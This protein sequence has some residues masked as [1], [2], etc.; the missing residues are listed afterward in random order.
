MKCSW[1]ALMESLINIEV[2]TRKEATKQFA[3]E[4]IAAGP[5]A[6]CNTNIAPW[7]KNGVC[8]RLEH[9]LSFSE[10]EIGSP[11][12]PLDQHVVE[13]LIASISEFGQKEPIAVR[14]LGDGRLQ[15]LS[16]CHRIAALMNLGRKSASALIVSGLSD[17]E[18][19]IW[20][21]VD[22]LH[23]K[24]LSVMDRAK[25]DVELQQ[26]VKQKVSQVARPLGGP[27]PADK[28]HAKAA[29]LLGTSADRMARSTKIARITPEAEAK[30]RELKLENNQAALL[31]I[32]DAGTTT[33][34]QIAKAI[35]LVQ[36]PQKC[37]KF[38]V[39]YPDKGNTGSAD[40]LEPADAATTIVP[41]IQAPEISENVTPL[42]VV[43]RGQS[44]LA[45]SDTFPDL[46]AFL[47]RRT[48]N[49]E[50]KE[51]TDELRNSR[52][53][54]M[55]GSC[56]IEAQQRFFWEVLFAEF[57]NAFAEALPRPTKVRG[58]G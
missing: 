24:V 36:R 57:P 1:S 56:T 40:R 48:I 3:R 51:L 54:K 58:H 52:L 55:L 50:L 43:Q 29:A 26:A 17:S 46:P 23:R 21:L 16:G 47:K 13:Q 31:K 7:V 28:F 37:P 9:A 30:I 15:L 20:Q 39:P 12:L 32:A 42:G 6:P 34:F 4:R 44:P 33:E 5:Q 14:C 25:H 18:A 35:E 11:P 22:N 38:K 27:Q 19:R 53:R 10:F 45:S 2:V 49:D 8:Q 41:E